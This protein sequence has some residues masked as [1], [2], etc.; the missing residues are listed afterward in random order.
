MTIIVCTAFYIYVILS[1][2]HYRREI[3]MRRNDG[4]I[5]SG[6][7]KAPY[8]VR[9]AVLLSLVAAIAVRHWHLC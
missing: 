5:I 1:V 8:P 7:I 6:R 2:N 9:I 4:F 3:E